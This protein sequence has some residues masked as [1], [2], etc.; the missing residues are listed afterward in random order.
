MEFHQNIKK[1][2]HF[3]FDDGWLTNKALIPIIEKYDVPI[4]IFVPVEPLESGNFW[5]SKA[6]AKYK[7]LAKVEEFKTYEE[8]KFNREVNNIKQEIKLERRLLRL[9]SS[10]R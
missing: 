6:F 3:S 1:M 7:S 2:V 5:W 10:R 4:T 9:T 8:E